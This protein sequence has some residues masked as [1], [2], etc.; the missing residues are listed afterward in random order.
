MLLEAGAASRQEVPYVPRHQWRLLDAHCRH[1]GLRASCRGVGM[2]GGGVQE[3]PVGQGWASSG[4]TRD[5][6]WAL[7][8]SCNHWPIFSAQQGAAPSLCH[9]LL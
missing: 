9:L 1:R 6:Q 7:L 8:Q 4:R 2:G 5:I 3:S